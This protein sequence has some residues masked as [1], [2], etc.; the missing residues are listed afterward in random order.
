MKT[1]K[2][3]VLPFQQSTDF[4]KRRGERSLENNDLLTAVRHYRKVWEKD[5]YDYETC[6][7]LAEILYEMQRYEESLRI[8]FI[9]LSMGDPKPELLFGMASDLYELHEFEY[10]SQCLDRYLKESPE[11]TY[12]YEAE[13][14]L[15]FLES[16]EELGRYTGLYTDE[17]YE[18]DGILIDSR[19]LLDAGSFSEAISMLE[20]H[21]ERYPGSLPVQNQL[22]LAYL[23]SGERNKALSM[24]RSVAEKA[25]GNALT[26]C[27]LALMYFAVN[28][29]PSAEE[30]LELVNKYV[31]EDSTDVLYNLTALLMQDERFQDAADMLDDLLKRFPYDVN[32]LHRRAFCAFRLN[33]AAEAAEIYRKLMETDPEDIIAKHYFSL[34]K[35]ANMSRAFLGRWQIPYQLSIGD[36][37]HKVNELL[38]LM[39]ESEEIKRKR[40]TEDRSLYGQISWALDLPE[41]K[42]KNILLIFLYSIGDREAERLLRDFLLR[43]N[44]QDEQK[45]I[46]MHLLSRMNAKQPYYAYVNGDWIVGRVTHR[47]MPKNLPEEYERLYISIINGTE[48]LSENCA[49]RAIEAY[50]DYLDKAADSL[51]RLTD[52]QIQSMSAAFL[53]LACIAAGEDYD[54]ASILQQHRITRRRLMNSLNRIAFACDLEV[55]DL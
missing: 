40:W 44:Q 13:D 18:T 22:S 8:L 35:A 24:Q 19:H 42:L 28:D 12:A 17:D 16:D 33:D 1:N 7:H 53:I 49:S 10:A 20:E 32:L 38:A 54:L 14:F 27:N 25:G 4:H 11:G 29:I 2:G 47:S 34:A 21:L 6:M 46:A 48:R 52:I 39:D 31:T 45:H 5:P 9:C 55:P 3:K 43:T 36:S 41:P 30:T 37:I 50:A 51:P 23:F 26:L 15:S